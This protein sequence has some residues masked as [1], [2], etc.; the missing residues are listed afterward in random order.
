MSQQRRAIQTQVAMEFGY[1]EE[2]ILAAFQHQ[3]QFKS[4]GDLIE[5][6]NTHP[7]LCA[8]S[9]SPPPPSPPTTAMANH[10][11]THA[12]AAS[13]PT[14]PSLLKETQRLYLASICYMCQ[15]NPR[16]YVLLPCSAFLLCHQCMQ[17]QSC[18]PRCKEPITDVIRTFLA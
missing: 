13:I 12:T 2:L 6:M 15:I 17:R 3:S 5:Y 7:D 14:P 11:L 16:E 4:A 9:P 10:S 18:C 1:E 8:S